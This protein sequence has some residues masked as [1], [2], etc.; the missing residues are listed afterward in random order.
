MTAKLLGASLVLAGLCAGGCTATQ[1]TQ[2]ASNV[3]ETAMPGA[4]VDA[5]AEY[6]AEQGALS[7]D[8]ASV[9]IP[10]EAIIRL[11]M[12]RI[13]ETRAD[14]IPRGVTSLGAGDA[15]GHRI[16]A[17]AFAI[18]RREGTPNPFAIAAVSSE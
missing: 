2:T 3:G 4:R 13:H 10:N 11:A 12:V 15:L 8:E 17:N 14:A 6:R 1:G 16:R 7:L 5:A 18:A 9:I